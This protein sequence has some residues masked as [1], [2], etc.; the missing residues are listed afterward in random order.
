MKSHSSA[1]ARQGFTLVELLVVIAIIG[2]LVALL[3]PAVQ[4]A[5][6]AARRNSCINNNKQLMLAVMNFESG[7][8][9]L[10]MASTAP[11]NNSDAVVGNLGQAPTGGRPSQGGDGYSWI[12]QILPHIEGNVIFDALNR[13]DRSNRLQNS[14]FPS[15]RTSY[16]LAAGSTQQVHQIPL[17]EV[18]CPSYPGEET[19]DL[20]TADTAISNYAALS[21]THYINTG[22]ADLATSGSFATGAQAGCN[23]KAYCGNGALPFPGAVGGRVTRD[24]L[25]MASYDG[26][27][28]SNI[29]AIIE[30]RDQFKTNWYSGLSAYTV[31]AWPQGDTPVAMPAGTANAGRWGYPNAAAITGLQQGSDREEPALYFMANWPHGGGGPP[32]RRWGPSSNH[33]SV[34]ICGYMDGHA[35]S[36]A[37]DID[38]SVFIHLATREGGEVIQD[39]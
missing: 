38:P 35:D 39:R 4:A 22:P 17:E 34:V 12:V 7:R 29:V 37:Q 20:I 30:T 32:Q 26:D 36:I 5:R 15:A 33:G 3:L 27:G 31:A 25:T 18:I 16:T 21:S 10:P 1:Q 24:G 14:A 11:I 28:T 9:K 23:N 13:P 19:N 6:E 8:R 2:I